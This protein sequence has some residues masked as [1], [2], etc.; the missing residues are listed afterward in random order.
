MPKNNEFKRR[1]ESYEFI[2]TQRNMLFPAEN[3]Q[4]C[5][6]SKTN[7][8]TTV[9]KNRFADAAQLSEVAFIAHR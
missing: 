8:L 7:A 2:V 6:V 4:D 1:I 3:S 5:L 9:P